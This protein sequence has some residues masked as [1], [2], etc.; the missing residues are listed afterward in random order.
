[1]P[2]YVFDRREFIDDLVRAGYEVVDQWED[3]VHSCRIPFHDDK[4]V[5]H[6]SGVYLRRAV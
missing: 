5:P 1:V 6:Y 4:V 3:Y 2:Q